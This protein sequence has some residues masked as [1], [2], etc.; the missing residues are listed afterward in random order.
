MMLAAIETLGGGIVQSDTTSGS[1]PIHEWSTHLSI[2]ATQ[3]QTAP[4]VA[5]GGQAVA[6]RPV[7]GE[8]NLN[9]A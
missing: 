1:K 8:Q 5:A 7:T 2:A 3:K 9:F 4:W 6:R